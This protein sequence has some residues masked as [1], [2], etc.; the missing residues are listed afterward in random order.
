[1]C[2]TYGISIYVQP[3]FKC[4]AIITID[5]CVKVLCHFFF[6]IDSSS[7]FLFES[8]TSRTPFAPR[9]QLIRHSTERFKHFNE[10]INTAQ[11]QTD[12]QWQYVRMLSLRGCR[13][14]AKS[15][16]VSIHLHP[17]RRCNNQYG[18][19]GINSIVIIAIRWYA[20]NTEH[21][22]RQTKQYKIWNEIKSSLSGDG[23]KNVRKRGRKK[24]Y[25]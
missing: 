17:I 12:F 24:N 8:F 5:A 18:Y 14:R 3:N 10:E 23:R 15:D 25:A 13:K 1:M 22:L 16:K 11:N 7:K 4:I 2:A 21:S 9:S 20:V 6:F 19:M